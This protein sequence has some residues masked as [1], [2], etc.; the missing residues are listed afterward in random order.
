VPVYAYHLK[1]PCKDQILRELRE[2]QIPGLQVL[3]EDQRLTI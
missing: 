2:L 1:P 3:E